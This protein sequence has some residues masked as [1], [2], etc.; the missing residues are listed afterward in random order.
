M[1]RA[2]NVLYEVLFEMRHMDYGL[3]QALT[4]AAGGGL[5]FKPTKYNITALKSKADT[6]VKRLQ[7]VEE[8][9]APYLKR[10]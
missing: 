8:R 5:H 6:I 9:M 2:R 3:I 4:Y 1:E 10:I 7:E